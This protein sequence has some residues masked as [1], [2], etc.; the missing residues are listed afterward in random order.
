[1]ERVVRG[2]IRLA[3]RLSV[4]T[5]AA[6]LSVRVGTVE[7]LEQGARMSA[8]TGD[9]YQSLLAGLAWADPDDVWGPAWLSREQRLVWI[10][11]A[12]AAA[13][14]RG[15]SCL[16]AVPTPSR[17]RLEELQP[18]GYPRYRAWTL[19]PV[20]LVER[21]IKP[22]EAV[23]ARVFLARA[24]KEIGEL[25]GVDLNTVSRWEVG[26]KVVRGLEID[27]Y[28]ALLEVARRAH[29]ALQSR[30]GDDLTRF[31][32]AHVWGPP[33]L[34]RS[35]RLLRILELALPESTCPAWSTHDPLR[36]S[37]PAA[38]GIHG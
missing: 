8:L 38:F 26:R 31:S 17:R 36:T 3:L 29:A 25:F 2:Q 12:G 20:P 19:D 37:R 35:D 11:K 9:L 28:L 18:A 23:R 4:R 1:M 30:A 34:S 33:H 14:G 22:A 15:Q 16:V 27:V 21:R 24:Q 13:R 32:H 6:V 10:L 7:R 5:M